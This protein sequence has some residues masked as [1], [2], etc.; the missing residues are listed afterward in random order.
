MAID[1]APLSESASLIEVKWSSERIGNAMMVE[2]L[3]T[4]GSERAWAKTYQALA[5]P[6]LSMVTPPVTSVETAG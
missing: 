1:A 5:T 4:Y 6:T 3:Q 2:H